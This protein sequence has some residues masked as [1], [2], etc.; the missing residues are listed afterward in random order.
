MTDND[1][2]V[3]ISVRLWEWADEVHSDGT[4]RPHRDWQT[5]QKSWH[6][7]SARLRCLTDRARLAV[8]LDVLANA[9]PPIM[10]ADVVR[11]FLR[12]KVSQ[13]FMCFGYDYFSQSTLTLN[14]YW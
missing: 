11:R 8:L 10:A 7:L 3:V 5:V 4:P 9:G 1:P 13:H 14:D 6:S 2:E 12:S